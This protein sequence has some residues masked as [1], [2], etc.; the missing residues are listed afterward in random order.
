[1]KTQATFRTK[2]EA[3][4]AGY[5][6]TTQISIDCESDLRLFVNATKAL[7]AMPFDLT[8]DS[9]DPVNQAWAGLRDARVVLQT[10]GKTLKTGALTLPLY[11]AAEVDKA[12]AKFIALASAYHTAL[13]EITGR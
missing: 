10:S 5:L 6:T 11:Q 2:A 3:N 1:M 13:R 4:A 8:D 9:T 7:E 12:R